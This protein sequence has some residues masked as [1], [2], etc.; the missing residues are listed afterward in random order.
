MLF[1][2]SGCGKVRCISSAIKTRFTVENTGRTNKPV[3]NSVKKGS[4]TTF[5]IYKTTCYYFGTK[6]Q[7]RKQTTTSLFDAVS[8]IQNKILISQTQEITTSVA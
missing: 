5:Y 2:A 4:V 1:N 8:H 6:I 7:E 3:N